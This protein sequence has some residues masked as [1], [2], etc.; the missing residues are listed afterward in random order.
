MKPRR[1]KYL[2][3][4]SNVTMA[5]DFFSHLAILICISVPTGFLFLIGDV[6]LLPE[7]PQQERYA[8]DITFVEY[9]AVALVFCIPSYLL[10]IIFGYL[11]GFEKKQ[12]DSR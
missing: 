1:M 10:Y 5:N 6:I 4:Y 7:I 3:V 11:M 12:Q 2:K 8:F 9:M